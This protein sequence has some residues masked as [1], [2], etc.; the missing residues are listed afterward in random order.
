MNRNLALT[1][2][3][4]IVS[5]LACNLPGSGRVSEADALLTQAVEDLTSTAQTAAAQPTATSSATPTQ[6][7]TATQGSTPTATVTGV[8]CNKIAFVTD[9]TIPDDTVLA[10]NQSFTKTWRLQN[11]GSCSWTTSYQLVFDSGE[12]MGGPSQQALTDHTVA[13]QE[14][15]EVSVDLKAPGSAGT[16]RGNWK[17]REPGGEVFGLASGPFWV[18]IKAQDVVVTLPD[19]PLRKNGDTGPEVYALQH[20]LIAKGEGLDADGIFGPITK[21]RTEHFQ[22]TNGLNPDG[23]VG[24][25]TWAKLIIQ[26]KQGATGNQVR[27][28]QVLLHDKFGYG[29][30]VDGIFGPDTDA[31]VRDY[32]ADHGLS[33]DGIVGPNTWQSLVGS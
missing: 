26:A 32:Q 12:Q 6:P 22:S 17:I 3:A 27:A 25:L 7:A 31:A 24:P 30:S 10:L 8:P 33:V 28:I 19:W 14:T 15:V 18:Q 1:I 23:I 5:A 11:V 21:S 2:T 20:L 13:S 9:V 4:L 16:Y 29:L